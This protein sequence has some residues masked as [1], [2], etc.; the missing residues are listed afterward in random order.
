MATTSEA[1]VAGKRPAELVDRRARAQTTTEAVVLHAGYT[2]LCSSRNGTI[3][4]DPHGLFHFDTRILSRHRLTLD[5][6]EL[7]LISDGRPEADASWAVLCLARP[8]D[9]RGSVLPQDVLELDMRRRVGHGLREELVARNRSAKGWHGRL[10]IELDADFADMAEVGRERRQTGQLT[11]AWDASER[12]L[13]FDYTAEHR[14]T[15]LARAS[16]VRVV[17]S[18][19]E[20]GWDGGAL[21]FEL[22]L[23][24]HASSRVVLSIESNVD[25]TWR[26]PDEPLLDG[27]NRG[28]REWR[29]TR[30]SIET[31][32]PLRSVIAQAADDLFDLRNQ[33]LETAYDVATGQP[34]WFVN[35]GVPRFTGVFG[36]DALTAGWQAALLGSEFARGAIEVA[37]R[38]QSTVDDPW[39]DA[40]PGKMIH[41]IRRG[42]LSDL[43]IS[44]RSAYYGTQTTAAMFVLA[45]S[46]VWHWTADTDLLWRHLPAAIAAMA[47]AETYGDADDDGFLEYT[48]R[49]AD[50]LKNQGWKDSD[51][52]IRYEDGTIVENPIATVEEQAFRFIALQRMAEILVALEMPDRAVPYLSAATAL[53]G[54]WDEA[55]WMADAGYYALGLDGSKRQIRSIASNAG[56]ALGTGIVPRERARAVADRLLSP[57]LFSGWGVRTLS[58]DHPSYNPFAYHLGAVWPVENATFALGL[59]RYGL[60]GHLDRLVEA[61]FD[62]AGGCPSHRLPEALSGHD[63]REFA[64]PVLYPDANSPQAWSASAILQL[65][66]I[67]LGI[68]PFAPLDVLAL[69]RPRLPASAPTVT[70][71]GLRVGRSRV[72]LRF[73]RR[74]D[75][76]A[77]VHA[78]NRDGPLRIVMAGPP[79]DVAGGA[80]HP[81][82]ALGRFALRHLPGHLVR[83]ARIGVG[84]EP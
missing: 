76:S 72:D 50:G 21:A 24:G 44:P 28:R 37:A 3:A 73:E 67:T 23:P 62:A 69:V 57:D 79:N 56:H 13:V 18:D 40:E 35:A 84:L 16:R 20:P 61:V 38:T 81:A 60:D 51:E 11:G 53:R 54:R 71:R 45:L 15:R 6:Q 10:T 1:P 82:E 14:G 68:Y 66:Q 64:A 36:R 47:W 25:G 30:P 43:G 4:D 26:V 58:S 70:I 75:G 80:L 74:P 19:T 12:S 29:T 32:E 42:P 59:R 39:R 33:E 55:F 83:A 34:A 27:R 78:E 41:E 49:S 2:V 65:L 77:R 63:R 52:A 7:R 48:T 17:D 5:G 8:G 46:E 9:A 31:A 22:D